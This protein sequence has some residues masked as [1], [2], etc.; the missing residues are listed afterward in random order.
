MHILRR[1][2]NFACLL[3]WYGM[4]WLYTKHITVLSPTVYH[5][6]LGINNDTVKRLE[7][8]Y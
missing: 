2:Y 7:D 1:E 6:G 5:F 4:V 8:S 3:V